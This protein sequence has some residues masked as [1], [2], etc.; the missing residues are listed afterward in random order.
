M[1]DRLVDVIQADSR[2]AIIE[3]SDNYLHIEFT[4]PVF[5]FI[6]DAEF[7]HRPDTQTIEVRSASRLGWSD[8][9]ANRSRIERLRQQLS[10][11]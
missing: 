8:L 7:L 4:T 10:G 5:R 6:D 3:S 2:A 11:E 9:G 1:F